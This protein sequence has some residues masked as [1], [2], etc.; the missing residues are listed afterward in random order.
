MERRPRILYACHPAL[1]AGRI[2]RFSFLDEEIT[3]LAE[4]G[5]E[6]HVVARLDPGP[7]PEGVHVHMLPADV[8]ARS[9][10]GA[11][12]MLAGADH[13]PRRQL[14]RCAK[15]VLNAAVRERI[16]ADIVV[17]EGLDLIH[18]QFGWPGGLGGSLAARAAGVPLLVSFRGMDIQISRELNYGL[19]RRP[20]HRLLIPVLTTRP[21]LALFASEYMR[22]LGESLGADPARTA[23]IL[24]G[25]DV[26]KF[27]PATDRI[28]LRRHLLES[29]E[30]LLLSVSRLIPLKGVDVTLKALSRL[31][32]SNRFTFVVCGIGP[33]LARLK[34]LAFDLQIS[35]RVQFLGQLP[36]NVIPDYFSA[37]DVF[38]HGGWMEAA[39]N[40]VLEAMASGRP[41]VST[42]CG[43]PAEYC[44]HGEAG[45]IVPVNDD[46]ALAKRIA[47]LLDN[48]SAA[49]AMGAR[50]RQ[51]VEENLDRRGSARQQISQYWNVLA[52]KADSYAARPA[53]AVRWCYANGDNPGGRRAYETPHS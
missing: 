36:R 8:S 15:P 2:T 11:L 9:G 52:S 35:D 53:A 14:M 42:D 3:S 51:H 48:P 37:C 34:S 5:V 27:R 45:F 30:P 40:V 38:V 44:P 12:R 41:V 39:G 29:D 21:D 50:G 22:R 19:M 4:A 43:G 33:E 47:S 24:H 1:E 46:A 7:L 25:V 31:R 28:G 32:E 16:L 17:T 6:V 18:S 10:L 26:E 13:L 23:V 20:E 49:D